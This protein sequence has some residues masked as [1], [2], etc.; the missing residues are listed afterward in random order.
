MRRNIILG[1]IFLVFAVF[2]SC[3][4][5]LNTDSNSVFTETT[6]FSNID[7]AEKVV[8]GVYDNLASVNLFGSFF[9]WYNCDSDIE[10]VI[11]AN[12]GGTFNIAHYDANPGISNLNT[13]WNLFYSSIE[14]ANICIDN[15]PKSPIWEGEYAAEA[16]R[17]YG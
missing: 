15:L 9:L 10:F 5:Y 1:I 17:I 11:A 16:R 4:D 6:S 13:W 7:F 14:R 12:N 3:E 8:N 2:A